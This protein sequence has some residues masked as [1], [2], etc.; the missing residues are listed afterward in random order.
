MAN[1]QIMTRETFVFDVWLKQNELFQ[2]K[3]LFV[4]HNLIAIDK[5]CITSDEFKNLMCDNELMIKSHL[6]PKVFSAVSN[7]QQLQPK[8]SP[9]QQIVITEQESNVINNIKSNMEALT[10]LEKEINEIGQNYPKSVSRLNTLKKEKIEIAKRKANESFNFI[11]EMLKTKRFDTMQKLEQLRSNDDSKQDYNIIQQMRNSL[12]REQNYLK[13]QLKLCQDS[14]HNSKDIVNNRRKDKILQIGNEVTKQFTNTTDELSQNINAIKDKIEHNNIAIPHIDFVMNKNKYNA[15]TD[16]INNIGT[17]K[18]IFEIKENI[19]YKI[20]DKVIIKPNKK[21]VIVW[22]GQQQKFGTGIFYGVRLTEN[23]GN[24]NGNWK[25]KCFFQCEDYFGIYVGSKEFVKSN[26]DVLQWVNSLNLSQHWL[27]ATLSAIKN[28]ECNG[29]D[30]VALKS[31]QDISQLLNITNPMICTRLWRQLKDL[32]QDFHINIGVKQV[33]EWTNNDILIWIQSIGLPSKWKNTMVFA[34]ENSGCVGKGLIKM[35][36]QSD[37]YQ[38]F[39]FRNPMLCGRILR[40]LRKLKQDNI[41]YNEEYKLQEPEKFHINLLIGEKYL[42]LSEF[43]TSKGYV[44]SVKRMYKNEANIKA[45][46]DDILFFWR[47]KLLSGN[48]QLNEIGIV[49][50]K[51][52]ITVGYNVWYKEQQNYRHISS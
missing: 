17:I 43:V 9:V 19:E 21:G 2:I 36:N 52:L 11:E 38:L 45:N 40:V 32:H 12:E 1:S 35:E 7:L 34:V 50:D 6:I 8:Q 28:V 46:I 18:N 29:G 23:K 20:G 30:I 33:E 37:F 44:N 48:K 42:T 10:R 26:K 15:I 4:K 14:I 13:K 3:T 31:K 39:C 41:E 5:L 49:D 47:D 27:N 51:H 22:I 24:C 16:G 25:G